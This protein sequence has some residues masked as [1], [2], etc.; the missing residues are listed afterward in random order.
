VNDI[1]TRAAS[2][3]EVAPGDTSGWLGCGLEVLVD[4]AGVGA[5]E[6]VVRTLDTPN[7]DSCAGVKDILVS[8]ASSSEVMVTEVSRSR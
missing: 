6:E 5:V 3:S 2:S 8:A 4:G 1:F 7:T